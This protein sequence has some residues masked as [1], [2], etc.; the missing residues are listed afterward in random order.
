MPR[1]PLRT[2][3]TLLVL[4][5]AA[6]ACGGA[7]SAK[8]GAAHRPRADRAAATTTTTTPAGLPVLGPGQSVVAY[9]Q[10]PSVPVFAAPG[11]PA[12]STTLASP[13]QVGAP[14]VFLAVDARAGWVRVDLPSRPNGSTGWIP[15]ADVKLYESDYR[16]EVHES[17]HLLDL[18]KNN[19]LVSEHP[20]TVGLP[21]SPTPKG[22]FY[23][24]ELL[25]SP[26]P[27]GAYGPYAFG[28]SAF[29][30]VYTE[31]EG[32]PGQIA[33]HGTNQ[34]WLIGHDGSHGCV[35]LPD[36]VVAQLAGFLPVGSP[37]TIGE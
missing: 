16:V 35:R 28:L 5:L 36:D 21:S 17:T 15:R 31:F 4:S 33:I 10:V 24:T 2:V 1:F 25:R 22:S 3:S 26:N 8:L 18:F 20:I 37:V 30:D 9:A 14:L 23:I 11:A 13:N 34:P 29:S 27:G 6:A 12:P 7:A 19:Q 32:G